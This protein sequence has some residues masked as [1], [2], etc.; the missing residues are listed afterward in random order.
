MATRIHRPLKVIA[1]NA[2][3]IGRQR[4]VLS[5]PHQYIHVDVAHFHRNICNLMRGFFF[6]NFYY[7]QTDRYPGKKCGT[8][9]AVKK[10]FPITM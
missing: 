7:Y 1:F 6:S 2:K 5:K 8:A 3:G 10:S 4:Y 9:F